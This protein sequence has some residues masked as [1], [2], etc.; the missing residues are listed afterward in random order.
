MLRANPE[1]DHG[2]IMLHCSIMWNKHWVNLNVN[3]QLKCFMKRYF[4]WLGLGNTNANFCPL[5]L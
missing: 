4:F 1:A 3:K 5:M 2:R